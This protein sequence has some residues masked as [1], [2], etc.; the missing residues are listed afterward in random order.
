[1]SYHHTPKSD[2]LND[3]FSRLTDFTVIA[4]N[5]LNAETEFEFEIW[6]EKLEQIDRRSLY[7]YLKTHRDDIRPEYLTIAQRRFIEDI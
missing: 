5:L 4:P 2:S 6:L 7:F 1:M 3:Y